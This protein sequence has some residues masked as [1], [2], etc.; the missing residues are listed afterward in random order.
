MVTHSVESGLVKDTIPPE[1]GAD[2]LCNMAYGHHHHKDSAVMVIDFGTALTFSTVS[3]KGEVLGV[4][5][6]PGLVTAVN[7][8][9]GSTAQLPQVELKVP[10]SVLGRDSMESIRA[11]IMEGY[12]GLV[13]TIINKTEK[14]L[15]EKLFVMATGGL[16][17]TISTLIDRLDEL[18]PILTLKG[19][20]LIAGLN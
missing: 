16:S 9:F 20:G 17:S 13:E 12:A 15:G 11:G 7:A 1:L 5:I 19:L 14:E 18:D 4:A 2:L 8:L 10:S 6:A 3:S